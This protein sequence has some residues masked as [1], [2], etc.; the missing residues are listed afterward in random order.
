MRGIVL[1]ILFGLSLLWAGCSYPY[2]DQN[3]YTLPVYNPPADDDDATDDDDDNDNDDHHGQ[4]PAIASLPQWLSERPYLQ[5]RN[6]WSQ[7]IDM[8]EPPQVRNLGC[9]AV[10]N[11]KVFGLLGNQYPLATWHNLGGPD[12]Q[13]DLK[14]FSD[15]EP[16][17]IV[18]GH[19]WHPQR[20]AISRVSRAPIVIA[21]ADNGKLEWTSVNFA[22]KYKEN[23]LAEQALI[24]V[25]IF[26]NIGSRPLKEIY[27]EIDSNLGQLSGGFYQENN[28]EGR[29]LAIRPVG[30][31][32]QPG[33]AFNDMW[34]PIDD[35]APG[36]ET[37]IVLP[38]LF[39]TGGQDPKEIFAALGAIDLDMLLE[40][41]L[42]WWQRWFAE[43]AVVDTPDEKFNDLLESLTLA[44]KLNQADSGGLSQMSQYSFTWLR[45]THGP[46]LLYPPLGLLADF[47]DMIDYLYG[48]IV[49]DGGIGNA[50][51]V[52]LDLTAL[53]TPPAWEYLPEFEG[54]TRA[55]GPS[56]LVLEYENY[57]KATGD[58][59][60]L[61]ER[62]DLLKYALTHQQF[63][64]GCLQYFSGDETFEDVMEV[65][66][67]ENFLPDPDTS[68]LSFYSSLLMTRAAGFMAELADLLDKDDDVTFFQDLAD[69]VAACAEDTF[70]MEA[71]GLYAV[72]ATTETREPYPQPFEDINSMPLWLEVTALDPAHVVKNF[73]ETLDRL[74]YSDGTIHQ[75][76]GALFRLLFREFKNGVQT[77]MSHGYWLNNLDKMFHPLADEAFR[78]WQDIPTAAGATDEAVV[79]EDYG[80][81]SLLREPWGIVG[82]TSARYRSWESGI[83]GHAFLYHLTGYDYHVGEGW[84]RLAPHLPLEWDR[85]AFH[86]LAYGEG[87]FDL[88]VSASATGRTIVLTTDE[89][90]AF[91]L[92]LTVPLAA[93]ATGVEINGETL[94]ASAYE[95]YTNDYGR[96][97]VTLSPLAIP[98]GARTE[99]VVLID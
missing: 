53:P 20:Q 30:R 21:T 28:Y 35:L 1:T 46:S 54:Y 34:I 48:A 68:T 80:H 43:A 42:H 7:E 39:L 16:F 90:T 71:E 89:A 65:T 33:D 83:L 72:K 14:W 26:R 49:L 32:P 88:E 77:G 66:F 47:Q 74:G 91:E 78:R 79:V 9:M 2:G 84:A 41:T 4:T 99:I 45:D 93:A 62:Y 64:D 59:T 36:E 50:Y 12:Y 63:V 57:Y 69:D 92:E 29:R 6:L 27:L 60:L 8:R 81:L 3:D 44:I 11:G 10:G 31:Q 96:P 82:D 75:P 40:S 22:P 37:M 25:W 76:I 19:Y 51:P 5:E 67:G 52:N 61:A 18:H 17:V 70:W 55:E 13:I 95:T 58:L 38:Y 15:K 23:P 86:G 56:T 73:E 97:L 94:P 98:A 24:S 85:M 87:R